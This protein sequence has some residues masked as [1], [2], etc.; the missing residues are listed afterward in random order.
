MVSIEVGRPLLSCRREGGAREGGAREVE[1][2]KEEL[3]KEEEGAGRGRSRG[4][5]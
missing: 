2:R 3:G 1:L 5:N 4:K